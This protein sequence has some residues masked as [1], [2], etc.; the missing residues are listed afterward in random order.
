[1]PNEFNPTVLIAGGGP[2][3]LMAALELKRFGISIRI[4]D[5]AEAPV[6]TSRAVGIQARTLEEMELRGLAD[7]FVRL[8][9]RA[10]GGDI[11]GEA[12]RLVRIDFTRIQSRYNYR[13]FLSQT[14]TERILREALEAEGSGVE[15]GVKLA[16]F[17]QHPS[18]VTASLEH[19]DGSLEELTVAY[20]IDAEGAHSIVRGTLGLDFKG[21]TLDQSYVLGDL[22]I[23]GQLA[24]SDFHIFASEHGFMGLFPMGGSEFRMVAT[25]PSGAQPDDAPPTLEHLQSIFDQRSHIP[26]RIRQLTWSSWFHINS[27]MVSSLRVG[28]IF[29][30]GDA[31]HIHSPAGAQG[32]NTGIQDAINLGWKLA[33]VLQARATEQL[34][35]TY[36]QDRLP[37]MRSIVSRAQDLTEV[38]DP[39]HPIM[40]SFFLHLMPWLGNADF[41]QESTTARI[42]Q[43]S[44]NY[45]N[46]PLSDEHFADGSL[47]AGDRVPD[48]SLRGANANGEDEALRLFSRLNPSRFTLLV[49]NQAAIPAVVPAATPTVSPAATSNAIPVTSSAGNSAASSDRAPAANSAPASTTNFTA[50][51]DAKPVAAA[52]TS[53]ATIPAGNPTETSITNFAAPPDR[54]LPATS[55]TDPVVNTASTPGASSPTNPVAPPAANPAG[56]A[57]IQQKISEAISPWHDLIDVVFI[58]QPE[59]DAAK[60]FQDCFGLKASIT[61]VRPDAYVGFRGSHASVP[62]LAKYF[63]RWFTSAAEQRAA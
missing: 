43:I 13:L 41:V 36:E 47:L 55:T 42:S 10:T 23:D 2:T 6:T 26:A 63:E 61:L 25:N 5:E 18:G 34:L 12:K 57:S 62:D 45:R 59:G 49:A 58:E 20:L 40:R 53:P 9:N 52:T 27:R 21:K 50:T 39:K 4:V 14:E 7:E 28:R 1:M 44:L 17:A 29:L 54:T 38:I 15:W 3:G 24:N 22:H 8:G 33:L 30:A 60:Q 48:I 32:M 16:A 11:Y 19:S 46:S 31:A 56:R 51:S 35:D 37:V